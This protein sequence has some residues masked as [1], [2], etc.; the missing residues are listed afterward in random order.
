MQSAT[1]TSLPPDSL[2]SEFLAFAISNGAQFLHSLLCLLLIYHSARI[3]MEHE[4]GE[5]ETNR[6][7]PRCT[8]VQGRPF[9][10]L[11]FMQLPARLVIPLMAYAA[12]MHWLLGQAIRTTET[13]YTDPVH[14]VEHSLYFVTYASYPIFISTVLMIA[15]TVA[16]WW[17]FTFTREGFI[18]Q[19]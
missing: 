2:N 12:L 10:H 3:S 18:P 19:M 14:G 8:I 16:C 9:E 1:L 6:K 13:I 4:W 7:K 11:Y 5:R 17:A 15:M